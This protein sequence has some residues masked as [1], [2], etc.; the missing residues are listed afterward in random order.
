MNKIKL[1]MFGLLLIAYCSPLYSQASYDSV[2]QFTDKSTIGITD[3]FPFQTKVANKY[4][5]RKLTGANM[6]NRITDTTEARITALL[7]AS[8]SWAGINNFDGATFNADAHGRVTF[9]DSVSSA[10][11]LNFF[12]GIFPYNST[13]FVGSA[14]NPYLRM[15]SKNFVLVNSGG[16]DSAYINIVGGKIS[17]DSLEVTGEVDLPDSAT[18]SGIA[19]SE[20]NYQPTLTSDSIIVLTSISSSIVINPPGSMGSPGIEK[21]TMTGAGNGQ[22]L[23]VTNRQAVTIVFQDSN[24]DGNLYLAT[25]FSMGQWGHLTLKYNSNILKWIEVARSSP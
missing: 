3:I 18:F 23:V 19:L 12:A 7:A 24:A 20:D 16:T 22:L 9:G 4:T 5:W 17:M 13:S 8:N 15:Y 2:A 10:T 1:I 21:I 6:F 11:L 14:A 25:D